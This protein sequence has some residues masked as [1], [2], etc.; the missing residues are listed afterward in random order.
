MV[1]RG[2]TLTEML[3]ATIVFL[4]GFV[5]AFSLFLAGMRFRQLAEG[6]TRSS[7]T[8]AC[9]VDEIRIDTGGGGSTA[10][11][12]PKEYLGDGFVGT[13]TKSAVTVDSPFYPYQAIPGVWYRVMKVTDLNDRSAG[14][15]AEMSTI[16]RLKL[17]VVPFSSADAP[18]FKIINRQLLKLPSTSTP[19]Q[20][21]D[22]L[23]SRGIG[24]R[25]DAVITR[26]ASWLQ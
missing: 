17:L 5:A 23:V 11:V 18:T 22:E 14:A 3:V 2:F 10:P 24:F 19:D 12:A 25:Y 15:E 8:A 16:L 21:A 4:V 7:L 20:I 6:V 1:R 13:S 26:R 9:L